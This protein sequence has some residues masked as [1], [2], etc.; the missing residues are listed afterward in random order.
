MS[1]WEVPDN[2]NA[3]LSVSISNIHTK[4][5]NHPFPHISPLKSRKSCMTNGRIDLAWSLSSQV[6]WQCP[7][8]TWAHVATF[9]QRPQGKENKLR[10]HSAPSEPLVCKGGWTCNQNLQ[11]NLNSTNISKSTGFVFLTWQS[12]DWF[13]HREPL[14]ENQEFHIVLPYPTAKYLKLAFKYWVP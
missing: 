8:R 6:P 4:L 13:C 1:I 10:L 5:I 14:A 11:L 2:Q 12:T 9:G 7:C 3:K